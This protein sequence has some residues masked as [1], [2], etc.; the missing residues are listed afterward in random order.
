MDYDNITI[1]GVPCDSVPA[2]K[3]PRVSLDGAASFTVT[4]KTYAAAAAA[5]QQA[6]VFTI[7]G[8]I[9]TL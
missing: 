6:K 9:I 2:P 7:A 3:R 4:H 5:P 8:Q 1:I